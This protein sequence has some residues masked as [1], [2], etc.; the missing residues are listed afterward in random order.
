MPARLVGALAWLP[1]WSSFKQPDAA[2]NF[3]G[4][5]QS[6][7]GKF[8]KQIR[9]MGGV[10]QLSSKVHAGLVQYLVPSPEPEKAPGDVVYRTPIRD[11]CGSTV[12]AVI[13]CKLIL[14]KEAV[15]HGGTNAGIKAR[16]DI[17]YQTADTGYDKK[18]PE[19]NFRFPPFFMLSPTCGRLRDRTKLCYLIKTETNGEV[20]PRRR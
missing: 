4:L 8:V 12:S 10:S 19:G 2:F 5:Q 16:C 11:I 15:L 18:G 6:N 20:S 7:D 3:L 1:P 14:G 17:R 13:P 9:T